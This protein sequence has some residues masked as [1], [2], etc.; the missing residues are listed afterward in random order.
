VDDT[1]LDLSHCAFI[2]SKFRLGSLRTM[3]V[4]NPLRLSMPTHRK[5]V[6][7]VLPETSRK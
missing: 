5:V 7:Y 6:Q 2:D 1:G 3:F 4:G